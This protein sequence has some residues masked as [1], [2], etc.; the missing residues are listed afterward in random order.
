M[1]LNQY[2]RLF[3]RWT[4]FLV[5]AALVGGGIAFFAR[6]SQA[7]TY[8]AEVKIL[9]TRDPQPNSTGGD[10]PTGADLARLY[11]ELARTRPVLQATIDTLDLD[12]SVRSLREAVE[13]RIVDDT[14]LLV[15]AVTYQRQDQVAPIANTIAAQLRAQNPASLTPEQTQQIASAQAAITQLNSDIQAALDVLADLRAQIAGATTPDQVARLEAEATIIHNQITQWRAQAAA[16]QALIA[17]LQGQTT[18]LDIVEEAVEAEWPQDKTLVRSAVVGAV[19]GVLLAAG[20][21]LFMHLQESAVKSAEQAAH[22]M[23]LPVLGTIAR[24]GR[25]KDSYPRRLITQRAPASPIAEAYHAIQANLLL[26]PPG[27]DKRSGLYVVTS[28]NPAEGKS[29]TVANLGVAIAQSGLNVLLVDTDLRQP[30]LHDILNVENKGTLARLLTQ[31]PADYDLAVT[32]AALPA[33]LQ[34]HVQ[35]A[36]TPNLSVITSGP[37]PAIPAE[38]LHSETLPD[39]IKVFKAHLDVDVILFDTPPCLAVA[40]S[41]ILAANIRADVVMVLEAGQTQRSAAR[42][43]AEQFRHIGSPISGVV[44]NKTSLREQ[45]M[46]YGYDY[47]PQAASGPPG[48]RE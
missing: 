35:A 19:I 44:L 13:P 10:L 8:Q 29:I 26:S 45:A 3:R 1:E 5:L 2:I 23:D 24:F 27:A 34:D 12:A 9:I 28:P 11:A 38:V 33:V 7:D 37:L 25:S 39:W 42:Q 43:A 47:Q 46:G 30:R 4:W 17:A 6:Q 36:E 16:N 48:G 41:A 18:T 20:L 22:I 21:V 31:S 14:S 15:I 32:Q 40:D